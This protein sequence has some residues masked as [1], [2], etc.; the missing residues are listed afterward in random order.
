MSGLTRKTASAVLW[1][2]GSQ[3]SVAVVSLASFTV[4]SRQVGVAAFGEY[5]LALVV[6]SAIQWCANGA[7][8]EPVIQA[9][10]ID[11]RIASTVFWFTV[12]VGV[13]LAAV[14]AAA[15]LVLIP[16]SYTHLRAHETTE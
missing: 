9:P 7:Y 15:A 12:G 3:A 2:L 1:T 11:E 8:R 4:L 13:V 16:V 14:A 5:L 10:E 6:L